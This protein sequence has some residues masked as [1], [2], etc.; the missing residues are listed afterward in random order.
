MAT[1][2]S[3]PDSHNTPQGEQQQPQKPQQQQQQQQQQR[4][5]M[6]AK[7]RFS[8]GE[9]RVPASEWSGGEIPA[10]S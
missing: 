4:W 8:G 5:P 3:I 10:D 1:Y 2:T 7:A 6:D 9:E